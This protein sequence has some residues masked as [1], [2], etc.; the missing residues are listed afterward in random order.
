MAV[1]LGV[2]GVTVYRDGCRDMQ[3]M[4]LASSKGSDEAKRPAGGTASRRREPRPHTRDPPPTSPTER[5]TDVSRRSCPREAAGDHAVAA[6][7]PDDALRQHAREGVRRPA[8]QRE[9]EVFAQLGK[10]GDVANSDLEAIC[11]I[12]SLWLRSNGSLETAVSQL[13][14]IGSSLSVPTKDSR[15][16]S[17]ADGLATA[18]CATSAPRTSTGSRRPR[19]RRSDRARE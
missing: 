5:P 10:G 4:A 19:P 12:L 15:I 7:S 2:K 9:R 8:E 17:L 13:S 6:H 11:R 3:P 16:M 1:E 14:G 18:S